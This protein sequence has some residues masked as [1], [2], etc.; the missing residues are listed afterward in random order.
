MA[1]GKI[2]A[3]AQEERFTR[4]KYDHNFPKHAVAYCLRE[5]GLRPEDLDY[6]VFYDKPFLKFERLLETYLAFAPQGLRS[7]LMAMPLW[8]KTKLH[9]PREI[10]KAFDGR[11]R[12]AIVFTGHHESHAASA[13]FPSPFDEAAILTMD[14]VGEW[15]TASI[16]HGKGNKIELLKTQR[17]PHSIGLLYSAFTYFCGFQVNSGEYKL[18]GLA[19]YGEPKYVDLILE[20]LVD[21]KPDGSLAMDMK[22]FNYC[23][24]LT[25]TNGEFDKLF[26]GPPRSADSFITQ[27]EMDLAASIQK[28]TEEVVLRM[29]RHAKELTGAK[30]LCL[31]GGVALNCVANGILLREKIFDDIW[32]P[33]PA[34]DAGGALGAALFVH[35][36]LL[37]GERNPRG[38]DS[39]QGSL[40][41]PK[42]SNEEIGAFLKSKNVPH[43]FY[44]DEKE[45]LQKTVEAMAGEKVVGWFQGR[46]EF[47]PRALGSR[48][49]IGDARSEQMQSQM[50]LRIKFRESFRPF[51]PCVLAEDVSEYFELDRESPY[52]LLVAPVRKELR[53]ELTDEQKRAMKDPNLNKRVNLKRST[54][55][56]VTHVDMSARI[57]TVDEARHGRYYR[58]MKEFKRQTGCPVIVNTSFNLSWEPIVCTPQEAYHTFMQSEMDVLVLENFI[59]QKGE[60]PVGFQAWAREGAVTPDPA[61]PFADPRTGDPLIVT[62]K[63]V[64]NPVTGARYEVEEGIPRLFL[65]TD[66]R[67]LDGANVTDLVRKFYER[68]PFPNYEKVDNVRALLEKARGGLFARLLNEQIPF[69][70]RVVEIGCGTGQLTNLLAIAHRSVLG[71][72]MCGNSLALAHGFATKHGIDRAVFAQMNLFRPGLKDGFFDFVISNGVLHHTNDARRAFARISRLAKPGG[73]VLVGLYSAYSRQLHYARRALFRV[74]GVTSRMLDPHFGRVSASGKREAWFQDQYCHP[75][76]SCHTLDEVMHWLDEN[77]LEFVNAIPKPTGGPELAPNERM[78]EPKSRGTAASRMWSQLC[79][80]SSGYREGG[81]FIVIARRR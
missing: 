65:P 66:D 54:I 67:E 35:Y 51:A 1:D 61:C 76:E 36:Q 38:R 30:Y 72:D 80:L 78:F 58:L 5:A 20:K 49:L 50:N 11:Y 3:A 17:F 55:P 73:Y 29:A 32:I 59:L 15:D 81:F 56:A 60:Q 48:S 7:F 23:Q 40:L 69:D 64:I 62:P 14:G 9:L 28:V 27:R 75:H 19:P 2:V 26:G 22:Y 8:V 42:F 44:P 57:Q 77:N 39:M 63:G 31:A 13:F 24:G 70:A 16:G 47:G 21:L 46:M 6:V 37:D 43:H 71:T 45:L 52:M 41:G 4:E 12:K 53:C 10:R 33:A 34:G 79:S 25:M 68:T 74:T 18:M